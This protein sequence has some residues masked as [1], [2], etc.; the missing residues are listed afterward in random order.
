MTSDG[1]MRPQIGTPLGRK[2]EQTRRRFLDAG[3]RLL[4]TLS[5]V[6]L[7]TASIAKEAGAAHTTFYIYFEDVRDFLLALAEVVTERMVK[8]FEASSFFQDRANIESDARDY[9][10]LM[11]EFWSQEAAILHYR[12]MEADLG[13]PDCKD[14]RHAWSDT[15]LGRLRPLFVEAL[16]EVEAL[17]VA[18]ANA[19]ATVIFASMERLVAIDQHEEIPDEL[20]ATIRAGQVRVL[21]FLLQPRASLLEGA[22]GKKSP[23]RVKTPDQKDGGSVRSRRK[24]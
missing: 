8:A 15:V 16:R 17:S 22:H 12:D 1:T 9:I 13:D 2:G 3:R 23:A 5:P 24:I 21:A 14:L 11:A 4:R 19:E 10:M 20:V 7:T 6:E 18:D